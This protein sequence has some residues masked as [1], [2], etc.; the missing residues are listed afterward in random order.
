LL[1]Y[2]SVFVK[3][4]LSSFCFTLISA[5]AVLRAIHLGATTIIAGAAGAAI[6]IIGA[7][8]FF[9]IAFAHT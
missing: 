2:F 5:T 8:I 1:I 7:V 9:T 6:I 3:L 4:S